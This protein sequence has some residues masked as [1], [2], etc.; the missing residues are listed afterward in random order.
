MNELL[1]H[2]SFICRGLIVI[3]MGKIEDKERILKSVREK[4]QVTY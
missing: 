3:K 1:E 4:Q 2:N